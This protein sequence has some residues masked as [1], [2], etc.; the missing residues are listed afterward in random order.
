MAI[1]S[2]EDLKTYLGIPD[3]IDDSTLVWA[4]AAAN[5]YVTEYCGRTFEKTATGSATARV[6]R[7][8]QSCFCWTDDFWE[9]S[10]LAVKVDQGDDGTYEETWVLNTDFILEPLN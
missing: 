4:T 6:Y 5:Q 8:G 3:S 7:P 1:I 9:T 10:V 2:T